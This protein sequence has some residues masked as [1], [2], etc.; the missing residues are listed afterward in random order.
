VIHLRQLGP[1]F[2]RHV[3]A[4]GLLAGAAVR[5]TGSILR[6]RATLAALGFVLAI[7]FVVLAG[8]T[9]IAAAWAT[10]YRW[11]VAAAVLA[12]VAC[13][14]AL[15][16]ARATAAIPPSA[17]LQAL[18]DEWSKDKEWLARGR[19]STVAEKGAGATLQVVPRGTDATRAAGSRAPT[20]S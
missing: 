7:A 12:A 19:G 10:P 17:H 5:D 13:G 18:R 9:A 2:L 15:C 3:E 16:L 8:A 1:A 14:A 20:A 6:L 4:Y 11:W